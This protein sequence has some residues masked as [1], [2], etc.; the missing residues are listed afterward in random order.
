M[1]LNFK[2]SITTV[3]VSLLNYDLLTM[4]EERSFCDNKI[5]LSLPTPYFFTPGTP[6]PIFPFNQQKLK[7]PHCSASALVV[8]R[9]LQL[10]MY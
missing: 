5:S 4:K 8:P 6:R 10:D 2:D 9:T 1:Q 3:N 7:D